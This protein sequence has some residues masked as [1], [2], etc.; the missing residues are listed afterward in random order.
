VEGA[1]QQEVCERLADRVLAAARPHSRHIVGIAGVPGSGKSTVAAQ[2]VALIQQRLGTTPED[3]PA[4]AISMDGFHYYKHELDAMEDSA[5]MHARRGAHWTFNAEAFVVAMRAVRGGGKVSL[6]DFQHGVGDPV[7]DAVQLAAS[8]RI[9]LVEGNYVLLDLAPWDELATMFDESWFV[10]VPVDTAMDRLLHRQ[11]KDNK[12]PE[13]VVRAR[14]AT[15]DRPNAEL[16]E[17]I[18]RPRAAVL[19]PNMLCL[20]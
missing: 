7:E 8:H 20:E 3:N 14:I 17:K 16:V 18:S 13:E 9:V 11:M 6:P 1:T 2:V 12:R 10:D 4:V 15:N 19:V 5:A